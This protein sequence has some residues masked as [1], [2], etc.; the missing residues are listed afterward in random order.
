MS[1]RQRQPE[2]DHD[3]HFENDNISITLQNFRDSSE[4]LK[5]AMNE[6]APDLKAT[7]TNVKDL[8]ATVKREPWRLVWPSKKAY[9]DDQQPAG[10]TITVR[11]T[12][13]AQK[14]SP[15]PSPK[16]RGVIYT[17]E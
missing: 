15:T 7:G 12:T 1:K 17:S 9:P 8:T 5:S 14:P 13:K 4:K 3:R 16:R 10:E 2:Q 11:K 6:L